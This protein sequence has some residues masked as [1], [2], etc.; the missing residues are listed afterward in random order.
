M[1]V[2]ITVLFGLF[3]KGALQE[4]R[5]YGSPSEPELQCDTSIEVSQ[6]SLDLYLFLF[7]RILLR[8]LMICYST[9]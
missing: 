9:A 4:V 2:L 6:F 3:L 7:K 5:V 8:M 1:N